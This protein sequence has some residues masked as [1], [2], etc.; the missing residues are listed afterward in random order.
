[1]KT[2][3]VVVMLLAWLVASQCDAQQVIHACR[4]ARGGRVYQD[5]SCGPGQREVA[6]RVYST[7]RDA[8]DAARRLE[9][10]DRQ[11]HAEWEHDRWDAVG[12]HSTRRRGVAVDRVTADQRDLDRRQCRASRAAV[13]RAMRSRSVRSDRTALEEAAVD[14][15]FAL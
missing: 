10:I 5:A 2:R 8:P 11:V 3:N 13:A 14:A 15:C 12:N 4:D 1:M 9:A 6:S 7:P